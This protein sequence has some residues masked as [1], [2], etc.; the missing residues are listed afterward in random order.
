M[1]FS[2]L[3]RW[4]LANHYIPSVAHTEKDANESMYQCRESNNPVTINAV[5]RIIC[6]HI[7]AMYKV[8]MVILF[9]HHSRF[10]P[11]SEVMKI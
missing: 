8:Q 3:S 1:G 4:S 9:P 7:D 2:H 10:C 11:K 5:R 6:E